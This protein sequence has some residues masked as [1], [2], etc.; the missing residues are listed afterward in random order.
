MKDLI[1]KAFASLWMGLLVLPIQALGQQLWDGE[2]G[3]LE[4]TNGLNWTCN[5]GGACD[6]KA[7]DLTD[8]SCN[9]YIFLFT[10]FKK[11]CKTLINKHSATSRMERIRLPN[12]LTIIANKN[13][14]DH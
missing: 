12:G 13:N 9:F 8:S 2:A 5:A 11:V 1:R 3:D 14:S 7:P 6:N 4:W 10:S